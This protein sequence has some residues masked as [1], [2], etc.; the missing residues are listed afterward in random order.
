MKE[1]GFCANNESIV[2]EC[3]AALPKSYYD[4]GNS[5]F[6]AGMTRQAFYAYWQGLI[7]YKTFNNFISFVWTGFKKV[8]RLLTFN[9][10]S[11][12]HFNA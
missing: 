8:I 7:V 10:I 1:E 9:I 2:R 12:K 5:Y 4:L 3:Q 6:E 11:R